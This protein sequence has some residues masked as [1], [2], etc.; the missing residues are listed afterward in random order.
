MVILLVNPCICEFNLLLA[1][2]YF[3][4]TD[5]RLCCLLMTS[6]RRSD[7]LVFF[8]GLVKQR[9]ALQSDEAHTEARIFNIRSWYA[10]KEL[11]ERL[12]IDVSRLNLTQLVQKFESLVLI[13][14]RGF[15]A[16]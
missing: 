5:Y 9:L 15:K 1:N 2:K 10:L 11:A 13:D 6:L 7:L 12:N 8:R 14:M 3:S 16:C 4:V